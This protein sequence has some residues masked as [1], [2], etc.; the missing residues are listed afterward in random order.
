[1]ATSHLP[2]LVLLFVI[3]QGSASAIAVARSLRPKPVVISTEAAQALVS[4]AAENRFST[5]AASRS[6][7][8]SIFVKPRKPKTLTRQQHPPVL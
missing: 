5:N 2:L 1:M 3:P 6:M 8:L 7:S 4:R